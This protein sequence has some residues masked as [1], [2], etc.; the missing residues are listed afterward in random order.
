MRLKL[1]QQLKI[2]IINNMKRSEIETGLSKYAEVLGIK[3]TSDYIKYLGLDSDT[4]ATVNARLY[5][6]G[7]KSDKELR[8]AL[9]DALPKNSQNSGGLGFGGG[10]GGGGSASAGSFTTVDESYATE[11]EK[12]L[13][14]SFEDLAG[15]EWAADAI[16]VFRQLGFINGKTDKNFGP[17][18]NVT[19]AEFIKI[20]TNAFDMVDEAAE[21][22]LADCTKDDWFY[23]YVASAE[24]SG[25]V[26][27]DG[28]KFR[29]NDYISRQDIAVILGRIADM[30]EE[31]LDIDAGE[32]TFGDDEYISEYAKES[33]YAMRNAGIISGDDTGI[34]R[35]LD[36]ASR[37]E[38]A[39]MIYRLF[40]SK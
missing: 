22:N 35:P 10:G 32:K 24:K 39:V 25:I 1:R 4:K 13:G 12:A 7:F 3:D 11:P 34:F 29:P 26:K 30:L 19:R 37:A 8:A 14:A 15:Y 21:C 18:D 9:K 33:V 27:G 36:N 20:V 17:A 31:E 5:Q 2:L 40:E 16:E 6:K 23:T 38:A 28:T